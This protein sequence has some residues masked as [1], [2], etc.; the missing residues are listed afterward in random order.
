MTYLPLARFRAPAAPIV[1][2]PRRGMAGYR[3]SVGFRRG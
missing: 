2:L 1:I 3:L